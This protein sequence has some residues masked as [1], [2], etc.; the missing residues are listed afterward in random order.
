MKHALYKTLTIKRVKWNEA[1]NGWK[2]TLTFLQHSSM[3]WR[4]H[5]LKHA[6]PPQVW[7]L[8]VR[9]GVKLVE[10]FACCRVALLYVHVQLQTQAVWRLEVKQDKGS[11]C[12]LWIKNMQKSWCIYS[13]IVSNLGNKNFYNVFIFFYCTIIYTFTHLTVSRPVEDN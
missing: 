8:G 2:Y 7:P 1:R 6:E 12:M 11:S 4:I 9:F 10:M 5:G 3:V 13:E